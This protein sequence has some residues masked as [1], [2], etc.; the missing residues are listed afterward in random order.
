M[1]SVETGSMSSVETGQMSAVETGQMSAAESG[2]MSAVERSGRLAQFVH[3]G[4]GLPPPPKVCF[5]GHRGRTTGGGE[6]TS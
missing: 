2:R 6:E 4:G 5:S 3:R 1:S